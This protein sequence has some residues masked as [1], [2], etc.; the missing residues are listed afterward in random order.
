MKFAILLRYFIPH[1]IFY[2]PTCFFIWVFA[3]ELFAVKVRRPVSRALIRGGGAVRRYLEPSTNFFPNLRLKM[4]DVPRMP[5]SS[6][7]CS[8]SNTKLLLFASNAPT[9]Y[10]HQYSQFLRIS[11]FLRIG[12]RPCFTFGRIIKTWVPFQS[13]SKKY[14]RGP[15]FRAL[16]SILTL[17]LPGFLGPCV[18][19][20]G[21][22]TPAV[23]F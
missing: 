21:R 13:S 23:I 5:P 17:F 12:Q 14:Y 9:G 20:G 3:F 19:G 22:F 2:L 10:M 8:E 18:T 15:N 7:Y 6:L 1:K 16:Q 4:G 11:C